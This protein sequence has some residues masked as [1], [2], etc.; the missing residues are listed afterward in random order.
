MKASG[1][2][3]AVNKAVRIC[4]FLIDIG[5]SVNVLMRV[6]LRN[7]ANC[8]CVCVSVHAYMFMLGAEL[9]EVTHATRQPEKAI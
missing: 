1:Y 6:L 2:R 9:R 7:K 5:P 3:N 4:K 8:V